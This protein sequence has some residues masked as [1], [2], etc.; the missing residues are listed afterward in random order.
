MIIELKVK[1]LKIDYNNRYLKTEIVQ[2]KQCMFFGQFMFERFNEKSI[3]KLQWNA[4][5]KLKDI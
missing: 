4:L 2:L 1:P 5:P 3:A